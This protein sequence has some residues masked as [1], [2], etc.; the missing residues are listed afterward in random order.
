M[1]LRREGSSGH[2]VRRLSGLLFKRDVSTTSSSVL[3]APVSSVLN[4]RVRFS[5]SPQ[6]RLREVPPR[7]TPVVFPIEPRKKPRDDPGQ[8]GVSM[9][10]PFPGT[11]ALEPIATSKPA[12][13][14]TTLD[15]GMVIA[16]EENYDQSSTV[17]VFVSAGSANEQVETNGVT[18]LLQRMGFKVCLSDFNIR[19]CS[20]CAIAKDA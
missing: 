2:S 18:H 4:R 8:S 20:I 14:M 10:T 13:F 19:V 17:G 5:S 1:F 15:N 9:R 6:R 11:P 3:A 12:T 16:T 7:P